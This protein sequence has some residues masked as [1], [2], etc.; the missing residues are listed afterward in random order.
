MTALVTVNRLTPA[1]ILVSLLAAFFWGAVHALTP[2][3]GKTIVAAYLV[4]ARGTARHA[5]F[6]GLLVTLTHTAGVFALAGITLWLSR[7]ILPETLY[8]WL[9]LTSGTLVVGMGVTL[10]FTRF[11][12]ARGQDG[13][14]RVRHAAEQRGAT[15]GGHPHT[16]MLPGADDVPVTWRSSTRIGRQRRADPV[17]VGA[18]SAAG[19]HRAESP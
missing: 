14:Q 10:A 12:A 8:P 5:L 9:N 6:L 13:A 3:H 16:H 2:G 1:V 17:S 4:G 18:H 7:Y 11:R 19:R 15:R